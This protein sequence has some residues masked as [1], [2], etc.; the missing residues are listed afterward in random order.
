M[1]GDGRDSVLQNEIRILCW[2]DEMKGKFRSFLFSSTF[3]KALEVD[4]NRVPDDRRRGDAVEV[5][6]VENSP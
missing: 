4:G 5:S 6:K 3:S 1:V 2:K